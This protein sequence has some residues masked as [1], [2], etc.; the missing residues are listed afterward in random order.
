MRSSPS[1]PARPDSPGPGGPGAVLVLVLVLVPVLLT[2]RAWLRAASLLRGPPAP[3]ACPSPAGPPPNQWMG[4]EGSPSTP[5]RIPISGQREPSSY[6]RHHHCSRP[7]RPAPTAS[8]D[9][10]LLAGEVR[11]LGPPTDSCTKSRPGSAHAMAGSIYCG[12][13]LSWSGCARDRCPVRQP[14]PGPLLHRAA[15]QPRDTS[16][17]AAIWGP[18]TKTFATAA[19]SVKKWWRRTSGLTA[20][21]LRPAHRPDRSLQPPPVP[22]RRRRPRCRRRRS[23]C[24]GGPSAARTS[25]PGPA[26]HPR[27]GQ[28]V[29]RPHLRNPVLPFRRRTLQRWCSRTPGPGAS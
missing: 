7:A 16:S 9:P 10:E 17:L 20:A 2:G 18:F 1:R 14:R 19:H 15:A 23:R 3:R 6:H 5:S 21:T 25:C 8:K 11:I 4:G 26:E 29:R 13:S 22:R 12:P 28:T 27:G 24:A